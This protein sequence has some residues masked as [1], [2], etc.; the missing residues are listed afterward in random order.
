MVSWS[1]YALGLLAQ[2]AL[3]DSALFTSLLG[4]LNLAGS[5]GRTALLLA[6]A[7]GLSPVPPTGG[8]ESADLDPELPDEI[9]AHT[10]VAGEAAGH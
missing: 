4:W 1:G 8:S 6:L 7:I 2:A 9:R 10:E 3:L 5:I